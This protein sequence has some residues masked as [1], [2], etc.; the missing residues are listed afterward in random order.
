MVPVISKFFG[1]RPGE[2][3]LVN[4][5]EAAVRE[6]RHALLQAISAM[7]KNRADLSHLSGF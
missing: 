3:V 7:Q 2:G 5:P 6:N 1:E 4:A